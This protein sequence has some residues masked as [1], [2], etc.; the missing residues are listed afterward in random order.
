MGFD[1][2][3]ARGKV[4]KSV[5]KSTGHG[6]TIT[7]EFADGTQ[8]DVWAFDRPDRLQIVLWNP[9]D[10]NVIADRRSTDCKE[11]TDEVFRKLRNR[12][13]PVVYEVPFKTYHRPDYVP[14]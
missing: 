3:E 4:V 6:D 2:W 8:L 11:Y 1:V 13:P 10:N 5:H 9:D 7:I 14:G 12:T